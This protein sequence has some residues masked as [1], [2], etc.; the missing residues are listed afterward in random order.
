MFAVI[1][2][3]DIKKYYNK[4]INEIKKLKGH[5]FLDDAEIDKD[6]MDMIF[7]M[8]WKYYESETSRGNKIISK[9]KI[10]CSAV[11]LILSI[12]SVA[13][14]DTIIHFNSSSCCQ[15]MAVLLFLITV[16]YFLLA[17]ISSLLAL[18]LTTVNKI[19]A[20][21]IIDIQKLSINNQTSDCDD[22]K[23]MRQK[24]TIN[25][26]IYYTKLNEQIDNIMASYVG[27]SQE[28]YRKGIISLVAFLMI[29]FIF[30]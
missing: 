23:K 25:K 4:E 8:T 10:Y 11:G 1:E 16:A 28:S 29:A 6:S 21:D 9:A 13:S 12:F 2:L 3:L 19:G 14:R 20:S 17:V 7:E 26:L 18:K 30:R 22:A 27:I 15:S 5:N 24:H